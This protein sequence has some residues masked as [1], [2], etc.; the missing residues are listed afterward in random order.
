M[1]FLHGRV[2]GDG[3]A[4]PEERASLTFNGVARAALARAEGGEVTIGVRPE[5]IVFTDRPAEGGLL[6]IAGTVDTVE[7]LGHTT[8]VRAKMASNK[9]LSALISGKARLSEGEA[10][11]ATFPPDRLYLF[12]QKSERALLGI[13]E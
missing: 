12:D 13:S 10:V 9:R 8:L 7:P 1:N 6:S 4:L 3:V 5:H 2:E 11:Y